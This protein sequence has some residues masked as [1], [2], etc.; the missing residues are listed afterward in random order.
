MPIGLT[1]QSGHQ[2]WGQAGL[3][4]TNESMRSRERGWI[5]ILV[6]GCL[7]LSSS[8]ATDYE[9]RSIGEV[10]QSQ[11]AELHRGQD[12]RSFD[13][14]VPKHASKLD[15]QLARF[16]ILEVVTQALY[17]NR[18]VYREASANILFR[19]SATKPLGIGRERTNNL[20]THRIK[21]SIGRWSEPSLGNAA[22]RIFDENS[23]LERTVFVKRKCRELCAGDSQT[24][25]L[26]LPG[27]RGLFRRTLRSAISIEQ[28]SNRDNGEKRIANHSWSRP[29][30]QSLPQK[31]LGFTYI[32]VGFLCAWVALGMIGDSASYIR[33]WLPLGSGL[34]LL[35]CSFFLTWHGLA[36]IID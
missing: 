24:G 13:V 9:F 35:L 28:R 5:R 27:E 23:H 25:L 34:A 6:F 2:W 11:K 22:T 7:L 36:S 14:R 19:W 18:Q 12:L 4:I 8:T 20:A 30:T 33:W 32:G 17:F 15:G 1:R 26:L 29:S 16:P 21:H 31:A 3:P 10:G